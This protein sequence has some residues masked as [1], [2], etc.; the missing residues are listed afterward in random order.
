[1]AQRIVERGAQR[2]II[3][4]LGDFDPH[5]ISMFENLA[6]DVAAFVEFD[7]DPSHP[8][9]LFHRVAL[10]EDQVAEYQLIREPY[11]QKSTTHHVGRQWYEERH[12]VVQLGAL[13]TPVSE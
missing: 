8:M 10:T 13:P 7:H 12:W 4:S 1:M 5:G 9:P 11:Q 2:T 6:D 3:L